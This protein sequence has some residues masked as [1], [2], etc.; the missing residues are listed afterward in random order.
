MQDAS[1][2]PFD[3]HFW[4]A[5][6]TM[7]SMDVIYAD[8][9]FALNGIIDYLLLLSAAR[10]RGGVLRRGRFALAAVL[11]GGYA[12][13]AVL[14]GL[15]WLQSLGIKLALSLAMAWIAYGGGAGL[16][17]SWAC[18][19]GLSAAFGG[20]VYGASLLAGGAGGPVPV[21]LRVLVLSF[22]VCYAALRLFFGRFLERRERA[23]VPVE[24]ELGAGR[25]VFRAL[26]DTGNGL[27]DPVS[28]RHVLVADTAALA[29]LFPAGVPLPGAGGIPASGIPPAFAPA[30]FP[31]PPAT[32]PLLRCGYGP[33]SAG[34]FPPGPAHRGGSAG[35][36][37]HCPVSHAPVRGGEYS[38][39]V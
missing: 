32:G 9:L 34:L 6:P 39:V 21:S 35:G 36:Y 17:K 27:Y 8:E 23:V 29:C 28:G 1:A 20:A 22:G 2:V 3:N 33:G 31:G 7:G 14:P 38:A 18:F 24:V 37:A 15:A 16:W 26:R 4:R 11:G 25:A 12:L 13:A 19:L 30:S 10:L 5:R